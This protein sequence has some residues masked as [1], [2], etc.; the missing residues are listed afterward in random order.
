[1]TILSYVR[2]VY[3]NVGCSL[4]ENTTTRIHRLDSEIPGREDPPEGAC[5]S[6]GFFEIMINFFITTSYIECHLSNFG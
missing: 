6:R 5:S 2:H 1:M 4:Q 3:T